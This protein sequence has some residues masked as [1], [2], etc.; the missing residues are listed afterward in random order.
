MVKYLDLCLSGLAALTICI[1]PAVWGLL[2]TCS[3]HPRLFFFL[4]LTIVLK[5]TFAGRTPVRGRE[6]QGRSHGEIQNPF[7]IGSSLW[8]PLLCRNWKGQDYAWDCSW[9]YW[10]VQEN[11]T[12]YWS[13]PFIASCEPSAP[14]ALFL[15]VVEHEMAICCN[16]SKWS[17]HEGYIIAEWLLISLSQNVML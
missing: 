11:V 1:W 14:K 7:Y 16:G 2:L 15:S 10:H 13:D 9:E 4:S 3:S 12:P 17:Y 8:L 5:V 6:V